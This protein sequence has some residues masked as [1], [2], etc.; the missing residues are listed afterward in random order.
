MSIY[1]AFRIRDCTR[2]PSLKITWTW[3]E[4]TVDCQVCAEGTYNSDP[5][6]SICQDDC[7][8]GSYILQDKSNCL[9][10]PYGQC[11]FLAPKCN[12]KR[13]T[14]LLSVA[15]A[16]TP[17]L[18]TSAFLPSSRPTIVLSFNHARNEL[19]GAVCKYCITWRQMVS[20]YGSIHGPLR[21]YRIYGSFSI[22]WLRKTEQ[23]GRSS[24][25]SHTTN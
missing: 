14:V 10:C 18:L 17:L 13:W 22:N 21:W 8:A 19:G 23:H 1:S 6:K 16:F 20:R 25:Q 3:G 4:F 7:I 9:N 12:V 5:V 15:T 2:S 24:S 11:W